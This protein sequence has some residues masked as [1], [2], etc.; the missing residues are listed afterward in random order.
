MPAGCLENR[1]WWTHWIPLGGV[2]VT[3]LGRN[4]DKPDVGEGAECSHES[5]RNMAA[6][7]VPSGNPTAV[8]VEVRTRVHGPLKDDGDLRA[9]QK[10]RWGSHAWFRRFHIRMMSLRY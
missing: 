2:G 7:G 3:G 6:L 8:R 1:L 9:W 4:E 10:S 5:A